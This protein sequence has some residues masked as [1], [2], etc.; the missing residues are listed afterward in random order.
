MTHA[1]CRANSLADQKMMYV[2]ISRGKASAV[3]YTDDRARPASAITNMLVSRRR[4]YAMQICRR[5][6]RTTQ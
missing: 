3:V 1:D 6:R 5:Q 2:A 4:R